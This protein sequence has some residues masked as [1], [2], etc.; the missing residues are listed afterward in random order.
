[1]KLVKRPHV[2]GAAAADIGSAPS[3]LQ[4]ANGASRRVK[5]AEQVEIIVPGY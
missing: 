5:T 1:V 4:A 3:R 2:N